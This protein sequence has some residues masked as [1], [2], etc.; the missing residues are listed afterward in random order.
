MGFLYRMTVTT[1]TNGTASTNTQTSVNYSTLDE[2]RTAGLN[3]WNTQQGQFDWT[4]LDKAELKLSYFQTN[5]G[6]EAPVQKTGMTGQIKRG[7]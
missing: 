7:I 1:D 5:N 6:K 3:S 4:L 2:A